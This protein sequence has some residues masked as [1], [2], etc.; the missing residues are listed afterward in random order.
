MLTS[1]S[2]WFPGSGRFSNVYEAEWLDVQVCKTSSSRHCITCI[3]LIKWLTI[4]IIV[5]FLLTLNLFT[6]CGHF[7]ILTIIISPNKVFG[8]IMVLALPPSPVDPDD[9]N[10]QTR[11]I[12]NLSLQIC[13]VGRYPLRYFAI[14]IWYS[15][16][17]R[18]LC[19]QPNDTCIPQILKMQYH[20]K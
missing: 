10:T 14:E 1:F 13:Y 2:P 5:C 18:K 12:F 8:D 16:G 4:K 9:V 19:S 15:P 7:I 17:T 11:K 20:H 6:V 3:I